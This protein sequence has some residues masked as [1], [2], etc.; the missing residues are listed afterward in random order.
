M[1]IDFSENLKLRFNTIEATEAVDEHNTNVRKLIA[2]ADEVYLVQPNIGNEVN[3]TFPRLPV[4]EGYSQSLFLKNRGYY[5]YI[6][7]Y[8]GEPDFKKLKLFK[9]PG[10]FTEFSKLEYEALIHFSDRH[11]LAL[12]DEQ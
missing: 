7:D 3:I 9:A 5:N 1:G 4:T 8:K 12:I 6:R 2:K 10:S 11:D